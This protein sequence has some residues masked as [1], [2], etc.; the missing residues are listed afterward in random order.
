MAQPTGSSRN[1]VRTKTVFKCERCPMQPSRQL[2]RPDPVTSAGEI[3]VSY[4]HVAILQG[5]LDRPGGVCL[6]YADVVRA[7]WPYIARF[8]RYPNRS[9]LRAAIAT[10]HPTWMHRQPHGGRVACQLSARGSARVERQV[11]ARIKGFGPYVGLQ[12]FPYKAVR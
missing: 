8:R 4:T 1:H 9:C 6:S 11:A 2:P 5:L 12:A 3:L 10:L 7:A